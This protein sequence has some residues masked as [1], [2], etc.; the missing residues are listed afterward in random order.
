MAIE[1]HY[2]YSLPGPPNKDSIDVIHDINDLLSVELLFG[3]RAFISLSL[4]YF[5]AAAAGAED[6][7]LSA[8]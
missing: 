4:C 2:P 6:R 1:Y 3:S 7:E 8:G 5:V